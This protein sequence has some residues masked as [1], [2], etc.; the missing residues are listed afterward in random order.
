MMIAPTSTR[1]SWTSQLQ[2]AAAAELVES[3]GPTPSAE[4]SLPAS[5]TP[6]LAVAASRTV[7]STARTPCAARRAVF[8]TG[9]SASGTSA[10]RPECSEQRAG[11]EPQA[12][13]GV[14]PV[15]GEPP[16]G[17]DRV[18]AGERSSDVSERKD[19]DGERK[20]EAEPRIEP[21][22]GSRREHEHGDELGRP[23]RQER[24]TE[25][26]G[27]DAERDRKHTTCVA[28]GR[29]DDG[30]L[31]H[32]GARLP[33][34]AALGSLRGVAQLRREIRRARPSGGIDREGRVDRGHEAARKPAALGGERGRSGL[35]R[36]GDLLDGHAPERVLVG[37]RLPEQDADRPH[38]ALRRGLA[39]VQPFG[40]DVG[41]GAGDVADRRE[42]VGAVELGEPEVE[43]PDG[44]LVAV[45]EE[46]VRRLHVAMDDS[47]PVRVREGVEHLRGSGD[48]VGIGE[49]SCANRVAHGAARDVLV[50]D[51]DVAGVVTDVVR[52]DAAVVTE[53]ARSHGL[54]LGAGRR[55]SLARD[56][57]QRDVEAVAARRARAR[58]TRSRRFRAVA[59]ADSA[60]GRDL[61]W[62]GRPRPRTP[63]NTLSRGRSDSL[64]APESSGQ[65]SR[66]ANRRMSTRDDD[67]LDFDFF[68]EEDAPAW[69]EPEG[70]EPLPP[71]ERG[72][73]GGGRRVGPPRNLTPLLRLV[74][75]VAL[76]ILVVVVVAVWVDGCT[77]EAERDRNS[78][79]LSEIGAIG[80]ASAR[81]G[82]Q[83]GVTLTTPGQN[84]EDLDAK[85][86]GY[87]QTAESQVQRAEDLD[88]P[89]AMVG[90]NTGAVEALQ[91]RAN[92]LRG[93]Q[94]A[95]RETVDE[96]EASI[97][98]EQLLAQ[99]QRLL[100]SDLIWT[101]SFQAPAEAVLQDEGI[102]G[103]DVPSSEF[104]TADD[105]V[106]QGIARGHLAARAGRVDR[107]HA[108]GHPRQP[109]RLGHRAA[110]R[111]RALDDDRDDDPG[112]ERSRVRGDA[113]PTRARA[114]RCG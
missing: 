67:I 62:M 33:G 46:D 52:A 92:G 10:S 94:N 2:T 5:G 79:Y 93:L 105:L 18:H 22:R 15:D 19:G 56:D 35:D 64:R 61:G 44:D 73:R 12:V 100:A 57:L 82:Q 86:G 108:D 26:R 30:L 42:R 81:L 111:H 29:G 68:D 110:E 113:S 85:L 34:S 114:R 107:R 20:S 41:E 9:T 78:T 21:A 102:E 28:P 90:P 83:L 71:S 47:G 39:A 88:P 65:V 53:P 51:V 14:A 27:Q 91:F 1:G 45:L 112:D 106:N 66:V 101:D 48:G 6:S 4:G 103:L 40:R 63:P 89:G 7:A 50:R 77:S 55:L 13:A 109:D 98:G 58:P 24:R 37:E 49:R 99:T 95:F 80:N 59:P 16:R 74:G 104:V 25:C 97:A 84:Q 8:R 43:E 72:R 69:Q 54:A 38:V 3:S 31:D 75:L 11:H 87:V 23:E 70:L 32:G 17:E 96:T 36:P 60:R 76:A